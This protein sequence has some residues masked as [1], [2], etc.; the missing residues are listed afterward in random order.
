MTT[1]PSEDHHQHRTQNVPQV[2]TGGDSGI[3]SSCERPKKESDV[4]DAQSLSP[5]TK[6]CC[7][8]PTINFGGEECCEKRKS[9]SCGSGGGVRQKITHVYCGFSQSLLLENTASVA[10][11]HL[12]NERTFLAWLRTSMA[13]ITV[14]VAAVTAI[15]QLYHLAPGDTSG[16]DHRRVGRS[17]GAIFVTFSI[18]FLYFGNA[19]YFH[20]QN[21]MTK[22]Y[23]PASRGSV[24]FASVSVLGML[25]AMFVVLVLDRA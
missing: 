3:A 16:I 4:D 24:L 13:L 18:L 23:F 10:R 15:T 5:T 12:A 14:G 9:R 19:R 7:T 2:M 20:A 17:I 22:G 25:L 21:A 6:G 1:I 11:D 8:P